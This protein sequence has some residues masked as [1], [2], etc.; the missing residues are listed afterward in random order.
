MRV[1]ELNLALALPAW[2]LRTAPAADAAIPARDSE[3]QRPYTSAE[4]LQQLQWKL[5]AAEAR[6]QSHLFEAEALQIDLDTGDDVGLA[7]S[8]EYGYAAK[9][10]IAIERLQKEIAA[11]LPKAN[12]PRAHSGD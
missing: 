8:H 3:G 12:A 5:R 2:L 11:L 9:E 7:L 4:R 6:R 10:L 1:G